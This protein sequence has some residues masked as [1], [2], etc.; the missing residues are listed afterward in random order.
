MLD[1]DE[2]RLVGFKV[3]CAMFGICRT[4]IYR[5]IADGRFPIPIK[6][7]PHRGSRVLWS[8]NVLRKH[9]ADKLQ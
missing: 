8:L 4:E 6:D 5:R 7:G 9:L 1:H 3:A 2:D